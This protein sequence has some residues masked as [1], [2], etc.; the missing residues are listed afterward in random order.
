MLLLFAWGW[1][2]TPRTLVFWRYRFRTLGTGTFLAGTGELNR[3]V[4][5][6]HEPYGCCTGTSNQVYTCAEKYQ[7][8]L[9]I[10]IEMP[11]QI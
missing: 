7:I 10:R 8:V 3:P 4:A 11:T 1:S 2:D 6:R 5:V 9:V